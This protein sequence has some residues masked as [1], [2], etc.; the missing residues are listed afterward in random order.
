MWI[1][2]SFR[3]SCAWFCR[4]CLVFAFLGRGGRM[5]KSGCFFFS[6]R[7][8]VCRVCPVLGWVCLSLCLPCPGSLPLCPAWWAGEACVRKL[9]TRPSY[10]PASHL[11]TKI[12]SDRVTRTRYQPWA[13]AKRVGFRMAIGIR[14]G[15]RDES[16]ER[17]IGCPPPRPRLQ[18]AEGREGKEG[19]QRTVK[20]TEQPGVG[21]GGRGRV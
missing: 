10:P 8:A 17:E 13:W 4:L 1:L 19:T 2:Q 21:T 20:P 12:G 5:S 16:G 18:S 3:L 11:P 6:G 7:R 9:S 14:D 15:E